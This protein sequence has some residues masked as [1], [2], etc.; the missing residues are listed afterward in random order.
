[1]PWRAVLRVWS[2]HVQYFV[3]ARSI[4]RRHGWSSDCC[5]T[6]WPSWTTARSRVPRPAAVAQPSLSRQLRGLEAELGVRL[7]DR[8]KRGV[9]LTPAGRVVPA[10]GARPGGAQ[11]ACRG[12]ACAALRDPDALTITLV[13]PETTVADVIAPFVGARWRA[14]R[15][16]STSAR[17]CRQPSSRRSWR[18]PPTSASRRAH[19]HA[20]WRP[21]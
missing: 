11:R 8:G 17:R 14:S 15:R 16:A 5:A 21:A 10:D 2:H 13:A 12:P 20:G 6:S 3:R 19:R 18:A 1:M 7:F 4:P 9:R